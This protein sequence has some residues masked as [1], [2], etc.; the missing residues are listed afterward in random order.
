M[1]LYRKSSLVWELFV[2]D[3]FVFVIFKII[4]PYMIQFLSFRLFCIHR[5]S[6]NKFIENFYY[7]KRTLDSIALT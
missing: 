5:L 7:I 2:F 4:L 3:C 6:C 1:T